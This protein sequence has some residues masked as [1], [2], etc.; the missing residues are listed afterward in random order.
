[1]LYVN[2]TVN[3]N[4]TQQDNK[5]KSYSFYCKPNGRWYADFLPSGP[6]TRINKGLHRTCQGGCREF[7]SHRSLH[8]NHP[9]TRINSG[10]FRNQTCITKK[11][12]VTQGVTKHIKN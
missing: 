7:E 3:A 12:G 10:F 8:L 2:L 5:L 9:R 1:M 4:E 11:D 6:R